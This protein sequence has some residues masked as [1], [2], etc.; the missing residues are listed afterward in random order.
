MTETP[1][2]EALCELCENSDVL[3]VCPK[4]GPTLPPGIVAR[5]KRLLTEA[6][7]GY[8]EADLIDFLTG[9]IL[10]VRARRVGNDFGGIVAVRFE[11]GGW[12]KDGWAIDHVIDRMSTG[13]MHIGVFG[14]RRC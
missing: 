7:I 8:F 4:H 1:D 3:G 6:P 13:R 11:T 5:T 9:R 10:R 12:V 14:W 2:S